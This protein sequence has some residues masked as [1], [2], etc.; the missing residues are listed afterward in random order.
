MGSFPFW[1]TASTCGSF[2]SCMVCLSVGSRE[3]VCNSLQWGIHRLWNPAGN[4]KEGEKNAPSPALWEIVS[5]LEGPAECGFNGFFSH[6]IS[7]WFLGIFVPKYG[8]KLPC[9]HIHMSR[10]YTTNTVT[11]AEMGL[12]FIFHRSYLYLRKNNSFSFRYLV[13]PQAIL[14]SQRRME[15]TKKEAFV[16]NAR[17]MIN[18]LLIDTQTQGSG[19]WYKNLNRI[20][21]TKSVD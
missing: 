7:G 4:Q 15:K 21:Q 19:V 16:T 14:L 1:W 10:S 2:N 9:A 12:M 18:E 13:M 17:H 5:C 20:G 8:Q 6:L 3:D 11:A